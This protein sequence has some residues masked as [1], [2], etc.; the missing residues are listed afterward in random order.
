MKMPPFQIYR[1]Q[2]SR[3]PVCHPLDCQPVVHQVPRALPDLRLPP[4]PHVRRDLL[5]LHLHDPRRHHREIH[6]RLQ[7]CLVT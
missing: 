6:R 7:V 4:V 2:C 1:I 5:R 3:P